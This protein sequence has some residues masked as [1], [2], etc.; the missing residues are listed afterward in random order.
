LIIGS[1]ELA[2]KMGDTLKPDLI[3]MMSLFPSL[4]LMIQKKKIA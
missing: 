4:G 1:A 2:S 3:D